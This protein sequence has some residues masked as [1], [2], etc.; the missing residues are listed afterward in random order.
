[1]RKLFVAFFSLCFVSGAHAFDFENYVPTLDKLYGTGSSL[2]NSGYSLSFTSVAA[3]GTNVITSYEFVAGVLTPVYYEYTLDATGGNGV[4]LDRITANQNGGNLTGYFRNLPND[5]EHGSAI[6]NTGSIGNIIGDFVNNTAINYS[7]GVIC[8]F[9]SIESIT[10][11][12]VATIS[13]GSATIYNYN[14]AAIGSINGNFIDN[15]LAIHNENAIIGFINGDFIGNSIAI[16]N[17]YGTID[18]LTGDFIGN[19]SGIYNTRGNIRNIIGDFI[20]NYYAID[21]SGEIK[22]IKGNFIGNHEIS[23]SN[24]RENALIDNI[25]GNFIGNQT[26][27]NNWGSIGNITGNFVENFMNRGDYINGGGAINNYGRIENITGNFIG[28]HVHSTADLSLGGAIYT[29]TNLTFTADHDN[30][31]FS[32]NYTDDS[33]GIIHNAIFVRTNTTNKSLTFKTINNGSFVFDDNILGAAG[34]PFNA[35]QYPN[36]FNIILTGDGTGEVKFNNS[37]INAGNVSILNSTL[38]LGSVKYD[39]HDSITDI[40]G[41]N[42]GLFLPAWDTDFNN[43]YTSPTVLSFDGGNLILDYNTPQN[44]RLAELTLRNNSNIVMGNSIITANVYN[45]HGSNSI[46]GDMDFNGAALNLFIPATAS[47]NNT[48]LSVSGNANITNSAIHIGLSG[49][50]PI[51][52]FGDK[53]HLI[54]AGTLTDSLYTGSSTGMIMHGVS[55]IYDYELTQENDKLTATITNINNDTGNDINIP[56]DPAGR[57]NPQTKSFSEGNLATV[58]TLNQAGSLSATAGI[59]NAVQSVHTTQRGGGKRFGSFGAASA[60]K[61]RYETGSHID[62][63]SLSAMAGLAAGMGRFTIGGFAEYGNGTYNSFNDFSNANNVSARGDTNYYG[64]GA[65]FHI[66][67]DGGIY[68][69]GSARAG[70]VNNNYE[71]SDFAGLSAG[72]IASFDASTMYYGGHIGLGYVSKMENGSDLDI[73]IKYLAAM[74]TANEA[75]ISTGEKIKFDNV[76]SQRARAGARIVIGNEELRPYIGASLDHEFGGEAKATIFGHEIDAPMLSGTTGIGEAGI[77]I[78]TN[79]LSLSLGGEYY[80][81]IRRGFGGILS[82]KY[83]FETGGSRNQQ[84]VYNNNLV[85]HHQNHV[86]QNQWQMQPAHQN[87]A[88]AINQYGQMPSQPVI[89]QNQWGQW[90]GM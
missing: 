90:Q 87:T 61:S 62:V 14:I 74:Q 12:F 7:C 76:L 88:R 8:N 34:T 46:T 75:Q 50:K 15:G 51:L 22:N 59:T 48:L 25:V 30:F 83:R 53:I 26:A 39:N 54:A 68:M 73:S 66:R 41:Y 40:N 63:K 45:I 86:T 71:S 32:G 16:Y 33:R 3:P 70:I 6:F 13:N 18:N 82:F 28:N 79:S 43:T 19:N 58:A 42:H 80:T 57:L 4:D 21:N 47:N 31:S 44:L 72:Q 78:E 69:D 38:R 24:S 60:G 5:G 49:A 67:L 84:P 37:I 35:I 11:D 56:D 64:G 10:G 20:G 89:N 36:H 29:T 17:Y 52:N 77:R 1:M 9:G 2:I 65:L 27:I 23:I 81:G 85:Q 55:L